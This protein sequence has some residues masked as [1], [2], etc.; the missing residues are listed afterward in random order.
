[1]KFVALIVFVVLAMAPVACGGGDSIGSGAA[2]AESR[3][4]PYSAEEVLDRP[5]PKIEV[6]SESPPK[7]VVV[8]DL[9]PGIGRAAKTGDTLAI[10]LL[11]LEYDTG[12]EVPS[13]WKPNKPYSVELGSSNMLSAWKTALTG[14]KIGGRR[15]LIIP[16]KLAYGKGALI[17]V[18]DLVAIK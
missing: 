16:S 12:G 7:Q 4:K 11:G 15:E 10:H 5:K 18:F 2:N 17:Y 8:K 6:P 3:T 1:M 13:S 9:I 14:M